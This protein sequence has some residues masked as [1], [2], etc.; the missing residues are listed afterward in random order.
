MDHKNIFF[1]SNYSY[2]LQC[3]NKIKAITLLQSELMRHPQIL[4][5]L[6]LNGTRLNGRHTEFEIPNTSPGNGTYMEGV[7]GLNDPGGPGSQGGLGGLGDLGGLSDPGGPGGLGDLGGLRDPGGPGGLGSELLFQFH[8][9][10]V[11]SDHR[12]SLTLQD[13][14]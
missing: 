14:N 8:F 4:R 10:R 9:W 13:G 3:K 11:I 6:I 2:G 1:F 12:V 7:E 5:F